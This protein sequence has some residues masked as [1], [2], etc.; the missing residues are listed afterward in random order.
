MHRLKMIGLGLAF[1]TFAFMSPASA[2]HLK[3]GTMF[4][5]VPGGAMK[6]IK[7]DKSKIEQM[8]KEAEPI[9]EDMAIFVW[10]GKFYVNEES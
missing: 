10:G 9:G 5:V 1:A 3:N 8:I 4:M 2:E 6:E 7:M